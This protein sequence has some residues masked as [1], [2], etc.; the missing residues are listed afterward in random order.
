MVAI[1]SDAVEVPLR[2]TLPFAFYDQAAHLFESLAWSF[3]QS[4]VS[5]PLGI[6]DAPMFLRI[7]E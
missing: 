4:R 7:A 1:I 2:G 6:C 3:A 5:D